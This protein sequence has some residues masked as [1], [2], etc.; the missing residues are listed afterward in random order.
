MRRDQ[1]ARRL[2][3]HYRRKRRR[4]RKP[5]RRERLATFG[6]WMV[7]HVAPIVIDAAARRL[8]EEPEDDR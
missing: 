8:P 5:Q 3:R 6:R 7:E 1:I 4:E 2:R